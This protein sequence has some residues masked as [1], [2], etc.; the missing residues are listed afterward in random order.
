MRLLRGVRHVTSDCGVVSLNLCPN[1]C[2]FPCFHLGSFLTGQNS[3]LLLGSRVV[4][5]LGWWQTE[6]SSRPS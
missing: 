5:L 4:H 3:C 6:L 1:K 2:C